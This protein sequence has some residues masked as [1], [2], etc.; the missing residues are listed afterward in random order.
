MD[1]KNDLVEKTKQIQEFII[2]KN[3]K[4]ESGNK[5]SLQDSRLIN[6]ALSALTSIIDNCSY[7]AHNKVILQK[8][9]RLGL[10]VVYEKLFYYAGYYYSYKEIKEGDLFEQQQTLFKINVNTATSISVFEGFRNDITG[11]GGSTDDFYIER[12]PRVFWGLKIIFQQKKEELFIPS[13][14]VLYNL[15]QSLS[16]YLL[17]NHKNY[18]HKVNSLLDE[19]L[20]WQKKFHSFE[21]VKQVLTENTQL[22]LFNNYQNYLTEKA[23]NKAISKVNISLNN[24][25]EYKTENILRILSSIFFFDKN[26]F[27]EI[28]EKRYNSILSDISKEKVG[29]NTFLFVKCL[30]QYIS[31]KK[32][33]ETIDFSLKALQK[34]KIDFSIH[35]NSIFKN[36]N[37]SA[38][39][40]ISDEELQR[41]LSFKDDILRQKVANTIQGVDPHILS[42]ESKKPHGV[43]EISDMEIP[44][45]LE[46]KNFYMCMPFKSGVEISGKTVPEIISYQI[47]RP[48]LHFDNCIVVFVSAKRCSQNLMNYVKRMQSKLEWNI[49]IIENEELAK[50]LK[51][52]DQLN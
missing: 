19:V 52:N 23:L 8:T 13:L 49:L 5:I 18:I 17:S 51:I 26:Y 16:L 15:S 35:I 24:V 47:F 34:N 9:Y 38:S 33:E 30:S 28:F 40:D 44:I 42:R 14:Y 50:L 43:S 48:F 39:I 11:I 6:E 45:K 46:G 7:E 3:L 22:S 2:E 27:I 1:V 31:A 36:Y 32:I 37:A 21:Y 41:L 29:L 20:E 10:D 25:E 4:N 12:M